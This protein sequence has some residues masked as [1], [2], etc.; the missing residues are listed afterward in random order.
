MSKLR[1][2]NEGKHVINFFLYTLKHCHTKSKV[3]EKLGEIGEEGKPL[4]ILI[5]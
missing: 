3:K 1:N 4:L 2:K 5:F